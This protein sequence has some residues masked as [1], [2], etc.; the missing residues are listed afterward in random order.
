MLDTSFAN[1]KTEW[2]LQVKEKWRG[3]FFATEG[4]VK[5][6]NASATA[7]SRSN[8]IGRG[9]RMRREWRLRHVTQVD[10]TDLSSERLCTDLQHIYRVVHLVRYLGWVDRH[11]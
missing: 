2:P 3:I 10:R 1:S 7:T 11:R 6:W 8:T 9:G 4:R 5:S